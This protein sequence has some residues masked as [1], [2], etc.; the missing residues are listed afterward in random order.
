MKR[1][2]K[3]VGL[4]ILGYF[5]LVLQGWDNYILPQWILIFLVASHEF[6][7]KLID[8]IKGKL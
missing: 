4:F 6:L 2:L 1:V 7:L 3:Y 8:N 5:I